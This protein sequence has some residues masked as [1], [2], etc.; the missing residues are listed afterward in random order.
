MLR[1]YK[2]REIVTKSGLKA[3]LV[4]YLE[5]YPEAKDTIM[6]I[7]QWWVSEKPDQVETVLEELVEKGLI[8][9]KNFS[10]LVLYSLSLAFKKGKESDQH[11]WQRSTKPNKEES[12]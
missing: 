8:E 3:K 12:R 1:Q 6:G 5:Q 11:V 4:Q 9:K 10:S 7:A 2:K